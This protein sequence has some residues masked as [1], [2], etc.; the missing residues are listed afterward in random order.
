M[1]LD[2]EHFV[3]NPPKRE[4]SPGDV[5]MFTSNL[6]RHGEQVGRAAVQCTLM[7]G[8]GEEESLCTGAVDL[9]GKGQITVQVLLNQQTEDE[10]FAAAITGGTGKFKGANGQMIVIDPPGPREHWLFDFHPSD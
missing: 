9:H 5:F 7:P 10:R 8:T 4:E 2:A 1:V 6:H 3:D